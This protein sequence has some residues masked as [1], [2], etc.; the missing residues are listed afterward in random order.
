MKTILEQAKE[1]VIGPFDPDE[2][3]SGQDGIF[4]YA[5]K[6]VDLLQVL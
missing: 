1:A 6:D 2:M 3:T 4:I 5:G